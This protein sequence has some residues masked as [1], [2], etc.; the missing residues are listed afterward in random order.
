MRRREKRLH[1]P[2][3]FGRRGHQADSNGSIRVLPHG[4]WVQAGECPFNL[5][6]DRE[7]HDADRNRN[8]IRSS[9]LHSNPTPTL[10]TGTSAEKYFKIVSFEGWYSS[11]GATRSSRGVAQV[12]AIPGKYPR[13]ENSCRSRCHFTRIQ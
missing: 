8:M 6:E 1:A 12:S 3:R 2:Q 13:V 7:S 11:D 10:S 4:G 5:A 9:F